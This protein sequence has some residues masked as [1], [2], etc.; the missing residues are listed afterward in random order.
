M[1]YVNMITLLVSIASYGNVFIHKSY[2]IFYITLSFISTKNFNLI[3]NFV[4]K[5]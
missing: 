2:S 1:L 4:A 3:A 5:S